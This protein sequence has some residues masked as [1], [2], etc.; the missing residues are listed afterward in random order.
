MQ[1]L[2]LLI[3]QNSGWTLMWAFAINGK[4]QITGSGLIN[5]ETHAYLLTAQ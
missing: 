5:G 4:E 1:D 3:D 2:N